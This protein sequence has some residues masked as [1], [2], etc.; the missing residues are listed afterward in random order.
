MAWKDI[1]HVACQEIVDLGMATNAELPRIFD[2]KHNA[3][4]LESFADLSATDSEHS[5]ADDDKIVHIE[6]ANPLNTITKAQLRTL[7]E[8][9]AHGL[10][11]K[12]KIGSDGPNKD[13][14]T[15]I[16]HGQI[17]APAVLYGIV[18]AGGVY[19]AASPSS[20][21]SDLARQVKI[22]KSSLI[23]CGAEHIEVASN[24][25]KECGIPLRNVLCLDSTKDAWK[26]ESLEGNINAISR[27][28]L[29]WRKIFDPKLLKE[30]LIVIL[31]S[32]GT[33]GLP[34]GVMLS[35]TNL[36]AE[37]YIIGLSGREWVE[38]QTK[39]GTYEPKEYTTLA[40]LPISH[41]AGLFGYLIFPFYSGGTVYWMRKYE[42]SSLLKH[43]K[44]FKIS[45]FYTVPSI[46]LRISKSDEI[47]DHLKNIEGASTGAAPMDSNL[48]KAANARV[49]DGK[50]QFIGQ[51]W[52]LS[53]TTGAVTA[54]PAGET[55]DTGSIS[56]LLPCVELRMV[57]DNFEDVEPGQE[58][59]LIVRSPIVTQGYY[60]NPEATKSSFHGDWFL[61]GDIAVMRDGKFYIVDRK[62]VSTRSRSIHVGMLLTD[63]ANVGATQVQ[64][65]PSRTGRNREHSLHS[66]TN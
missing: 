59:E 61:T 32:S 19:S 3:T 5:V 36:V 51:T 2:C 22:G 17:L 46:W 47:T 7:V 48:Q 65:S 42:W 11:H 62:K 43:L 58:G 12:Y 41:I 21:V 18:A 56:P 44:E 45:T 35:H 4:V 37:T 64:R 26:L 38:Q 34:K 40:H 15:V 28:K 30:S 31:W 49:G 63:D 57:N 52:G 50:S 23:V 24:A 14:V 6:A 20:T 9:I 10:R 25:A 66:P 53:E 33:T 8:R 1:R 29:K 13:T 55:D 16:S 27:Q 60:D 54:M 39:A